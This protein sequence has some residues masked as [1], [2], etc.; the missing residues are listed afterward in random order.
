[1]QQANNLKPNQTHR[2]KKNGKELIM[3]GLAALAIAG[4][5]AILIYKGKHKNIEELVETPKKTLKDVALDNKI[6]GVKNEDELF[7]GT[8][9]EDVL[10]AAKKYKKKGAALSQFV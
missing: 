2:E 9:N 1:M 5:A 4:T 8:I 7:S 6:K 10:K 3:T